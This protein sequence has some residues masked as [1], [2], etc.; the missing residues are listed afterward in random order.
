MN[1]GKPIG[2]LFNIFK[3][4]TKAFRT[5]F[6]TSFNKR[7]LKARDLAYQAQSS[8]YKASSLIGKATKTK[9]QVNLT[10][11]KGM[12]IKQP[13]HFISPMVQHKRGGSLPVGR[14]AIGLGVL[15]AMTGVAM[16]RGMY[17]GMSDSMMNRYLNDQRMSSNVLQRT[18]VGIGGSRSINVGNHTGLSL[19][20]SKSR[21]G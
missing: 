10:T 13:S 3:R 18:R 6:D 8:N 2:K 9:D 17:E 1:I 4:G 11:S 7:M 15:S 19:A 21:H 20:L 14:A 12:A 16:M 5:A